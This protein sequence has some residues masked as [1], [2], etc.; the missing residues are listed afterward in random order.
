MFQILDVAREVLAA[1]PFSRL[2][3]TEV[4]EFSEVGVELRLPITP[5]LQQQDGFVHGGVI[6]YLADNAITFAGGGALGPAVVT[7][8]FKISYLRPARGQSLVARATV[9][10]AGRSLAVCDC[11][12]FCVEHGDARL[13]AV[14]LGTVAAR[15]GSLP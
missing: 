12:V 11:K 5:Q 1:Q 2:L 7:S 13:C 6:S 15:S 14:A 9:V 3:G 10:H 4:A 8:E